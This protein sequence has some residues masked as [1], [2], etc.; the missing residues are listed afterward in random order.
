[1]DHEIKNIGKLKGKILLFGG[2]Y[3]N[4]QALEKL[5]SIAEENNIA[6]KNCICTGDIVGYCAQPEETLELFRKWG[7]QSIAGNVEVQLAEE[8]DDCGCNFREGSRCD[9]FSRRWFS[10]AKSKLSKNS[11]E[12]MKTLPQHLQ[13]EYIGKKFTV[14]HGSFSNISE[15]IFKSTLWEV[16]NRNFEKT[17]SDVIVAGHCG[18]PFHDEKYGKLWLNP[19]VIGMP[20]NDGTPRVWYSILD[21]NQSPFYNHLPFEYHHQLTSK[22]MSENELPPEYAQT[23]TTGIWDNT[24]ILPS[25]ENG[26]QGFG[27]NL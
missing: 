26:F 16:K 7:A 12:W 15:F 1:M 21:K 5:I 4:F 25:Q 9:T 14:V 11:I 2:I 8:K 10:Y 24:E 20:A 13:F 19:G 23:I 3:S 27:I 17:G 18:L 22:L 6:N